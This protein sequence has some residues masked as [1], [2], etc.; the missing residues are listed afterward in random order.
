MFVPIVHRLVSSFENDVFKAIVNRNV[1]SFELSPVEYGIINER[2]VSHTNVE[3]S[4]RF[5]QTNTRLVSSFE[6]DVFKAIVNRNVSSFEL[7]PVEYGII[8]ERLVHY[9]NVELSNRFKPTNTR[10]VSSFENDVFK[11]IVNRNVFVFGTNVST[12]FGPVRWCNCAEETQLQSNTYYMV[13]WDS[14]ALCPVYWTSVGSA[15]LTPSQTTPQL[16][17]NLTNVLIVGTLF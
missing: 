6:N 13:G 4:N 11:A 5:N 16:M 7:S 9:T 2:I 8:T 15:D 1:S 12:E 14:V 17:G 10:L 3:L